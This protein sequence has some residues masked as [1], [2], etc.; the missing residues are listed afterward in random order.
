MAAWTLAVFA[1]CGPADPSRDAPRWAVSTDP[2]VTIGETSGAPE[3]L[4]ERI[5]YARLLESG[6]IVVADAGSPTVR[7]YG[8]DGAFHGA[9]GRGGEGPGELQSIRGVWTSGDTV[10]V[11]DSRLRRLVTYVADGTA[12][13][14]ASVT[15]PGD[16]PAGLLDY[17]AGRFGDGS[18]ALAWTVAERSDQLRVTPD[19]TVFGLFGPDGRFARIIGEGG[20]LER[21]DRT[22]LPFSGFPRVAAFGDSLYFTDGRSAAVTVWGAVGA[23]PRVEGGARVIELGA[24]AVS[25]RDGLAALRDELGPE[26]VDAVGTRLDDVPRPDSIPRIGG[27]LI[28][29]RGSIWAKIYDPGSDPLWLGGGHRPRGGEWWVFDRGGRLTATVV[30]PD[31][32]APL[33]V[34][35]DRLLGVTADDL[36]VE[37]VAVHAVSR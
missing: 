36:D 9:I 18:V 3:L 35:G 16:A 21:Y 29:D 13:S 37:R 11:F 27:M 2:L 12:I 1:A 14:T 15:V 22:V 17:L 30:L 10:G 31:R 34:R 5:A 6:R 19:R 26:A 32:L 4:F 7:V 20:G 33:D 28:D 23:G 25:V 24:P 8:P